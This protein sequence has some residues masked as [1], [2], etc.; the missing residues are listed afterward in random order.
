MEHRHFPRK[1]L[2]MAVQLFT[3][4]GKIFQAHVLDLSAVGM[5]VIV[6]QTLP[7]RIKVVDVLFSGSDDP[8]DPTYRMRM[9]VVHKDKREVGLCLV[10]ERARIAVDR[11]RQGL[12]AFSASQL[13][14][15]LVRQ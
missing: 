8:Q 7:E 3:A 2:R 11:H 12:P 14:R 9:F 6:N 10:H 5:R 15:Q 4:N 1:S 13:D